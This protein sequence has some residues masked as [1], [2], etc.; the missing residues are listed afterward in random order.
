MKKNTIVKVCAVLAFATCMSVGVATTSAAADTAVS[1]QMTCLGAST[2]IVSDIADS[3]MAF[4]YSLDSELFASTAAGSVAF[5]TGVSAGVIVCP[6]E[7]PANF[8]AG[9]TTTYGDSVKAFEMAAGYW[10]LNAT[11][12]EMEGI[13]YLYNIPGIE[14]DTEVTAIGYVTVDGVTTYTAPTVRT[15]AYVAQE[16]LANDTLTEDQTK[17]LN[18]FLSVKQYYDNSLSLEIM[19]TSAFT[20]N[21]PETD[22]EAV[23]ATFGNYVYGIT[24]E[25]ISWGKMVSLSR[26]YLD[27]AFADENVT[28][29]EFDYYSKNK[30]QDYRFAYGTSGTDSLGI[31]IDVGKS[32]VLTCE[33]T[34]EQYNTFCTTTKD[35]NDPTEG[36]E[37][38]FPLTIRIYVA[39]DTTNPTA[40]EN[41]HPTDNLI[42]VGNFRPVIP[43]PW[44][45]N[46]YIIDFEDGQASPYFTT[47]K[48]HSNG[49]SLANLKVLTSDI[50]GSESKV[51]GLEKAEAIG[52]TY[53]DISKSY[54]DAVFANEKVQSLDFDV[55]MSNPNTSGGV[56]FMWNSTNQLK[57]NDVS[58]QYVKKAGQYT[59]S[60][61]RD[62]YN[63]YVN[64]L[65]DLT[66]TPTTTAFTLRIYS[67]N[68]TA[69]SLIYFDNFTPVLAAE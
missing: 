2:K 11:S 15:M 33:I 44:D 42:C 36:R 16:S 14:Y 7:L 24:E 58:C 53:F 35:K 60:I 30:V 26:T 34:R 39:K 63:T 18:G 56:R 65:A 47:T 68:G 28:S 67:T 5:D 12:G 9:D 6:E 13:A 1:T 52:F 19:E 38:K 20:A 41:G 3:G 69:T 22:K 66:G 17:T 29:V 27:N 32:G 46:D 8:V 48:A 54:L 64:N 51:F 31:E 55:Y 50:F 4:K 57:V 61:T 37:T 62:A 45:I 10:G 40:N 59:I 43:E 25:T 21:I 49:N 23:E